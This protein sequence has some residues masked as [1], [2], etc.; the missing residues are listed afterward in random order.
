MEGG[1]NGEV[2]GSWVQGNP[3]KFIKLNYPPFR[4]NEDLGAIASGGDILVAV[5]LGTQMRDLGRKQDSHGG[6]VTVIIKIA[7]D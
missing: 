6:L 1:C 3:L 7:Y 4:V 5:S 2:Q